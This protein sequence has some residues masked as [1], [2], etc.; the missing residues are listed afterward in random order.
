MPI[1]IPLMLLA[2]TMR[3]K[4]AIQSKIVYIQFLLHKNESQGPYENKKPQ[5]SRR[6]LKL[7]GMLQLLMLILLI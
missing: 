6:R 4:L 2:I 7:L 5:Q 1:E 3:K